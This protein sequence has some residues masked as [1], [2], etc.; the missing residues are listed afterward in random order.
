MTKFPTGI[1]EDFTTDA[2]FDDYIK[3]YGHEDLQWPAYVEP[4][5]RTEDEAGL[6]AILSSDQGSTYR[7]S[8]AIIPALELT[9]KLAEERN[10]DPLTDPKINEILATFPKRF[11]GKLEEASLIG[12]PRC[13]RIF[14]SGA[15]ART[16][17]LSDQEL[18]SRAAELLEASRQRYWHGPSSRGPETISEL[19]QSCND[20][21]IAR[22]DLHWEEMGE[23][24]PTTLYRSPASD[25]QISNLEKRLNVTLPEDFKALLRISN[26]F[27]LETHGFGGIWNGYFPGPY[28]RSVDEI[29]WL[30]YREYKLGFR[31]LTLPYSL[32]DYRNPTQT[33]GDTLPDTPIFTDVICIAS[34]DI[35]SIWLIPPQLM[36][37]MRDHYKQLYQMVNDDGKR[38]IDRAVDDFAGSWDEYNK[39]DWGCVYWAS[40]GAVQLEC[41]KS[42]KAWLEDAAWDAKNAGRDYDEEA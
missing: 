40:G 34:E 38:I 17:G 28:L 2:F 16:W 18:D 30:D 19:L 41:F 14:M 15:L 37:Q 4:H 22:S 1:P 33:D 32:E 12:S 29:D 31:Q 25:E 26:G 7:M 8:P 20:D 39:L 11:F 5:Q 36:Q 27:R 6:N 9:V 35:D 3:S 23:E 10:V 24:K 13:A 42:F 21:T